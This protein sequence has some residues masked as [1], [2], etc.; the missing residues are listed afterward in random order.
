MLEDILLLVLGLVVLIGGGEFLVRGASGLALKFRLSPMVVGLTIVSFGTSAPELLISVTSALQ[1]SPDL[2]MGNVVGSN[3]SNIALILGLTA[4]IYP[5]AVGKD[6]IAIDW[7]MCMGSA[8]LLF[9][10][11]L[12]YRLGFVEGLSMVVILVIFITFLIR[13]SRKQS[14]L[15]LDET[16]TKIP[17]IE[18]LKDAGFILSGCVGLYF[19]ADWFVFGAKNLALQFGIS[20]RV[21]GLTIVALG[22]SLP[23]LAAS[24]IAAIR[25]QMD[26]AFGNIIG[27]N[28][29]N[30]LNIL[31]ITAMLKTMVISEQMVKVDMVWMLIITGVLLPMMFL[32]R[33]IT[34]LEGLILLGLYV[35]YIWVVFQ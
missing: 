4:I 30:I 14:S 29:F 12:D 8:M 35:S 16:P 10:L 6:S 18:Y 2:A 24:V 28:I 3:I 13:K 11:S 7:P 19:G 33:K 21:I 26:I 20:E 5:V 27:S 17:T 1:G 32:L 23:E 34:R 25:R 15:E 22:T 9:L 31:G